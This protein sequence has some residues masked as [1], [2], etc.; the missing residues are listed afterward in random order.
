MDLY[1]Q[2]FGAGVGNVEYQAVLDARATALLDPTLH[3]D[4]DDDDDDDDA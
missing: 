4:D 1:S 2:L 3:H